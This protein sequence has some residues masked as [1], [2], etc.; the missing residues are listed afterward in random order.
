MK[1]NNDQKWM[2]I[3]KF[4]E[5]KLKTNPKSVVKQSLP[6]MGVWID[7]SFFSID[8]IVKSINDKYNKGWE[9]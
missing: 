5:V 4:I 1:L 2:L 9:L 6:T 8:L 3:N 7:D